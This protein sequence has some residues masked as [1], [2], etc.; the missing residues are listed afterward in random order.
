[1][2]PILGTAGPVQEHD[3]LSAINLTE[4]FS[5]TLVFNLAYGFTRGAVHEGGMTVTSAAWIRWRTLALL[6]IWTFSNTPSTLRQG[7]ADMDAAWIRR[8]RN[9]DGSSMIK[10]GQEDTRLLGSST[11]RE[12]RTSLDS[13]GGE[14]RVHCINF[15]QPGVAGGGGSGSTRLEPWNLTLGADDS[16]DGMAES[17][18]RCGK[19]ERVTT[20]CGKMPY[21][22]LNVR[23]L[24]RNYEFGR[25]VEDRFPRHSKLT[26]NLGVSA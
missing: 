10:E 23:E 22:V 7:S 1:M 12:A 11:G 16:G 2:P 24:D 5:P 19:Y 21:E 6:S 14:W 8:H 4:T 13:C 3:H 25:F 17:S 15:T 26:L 9:R 18:H 20:E